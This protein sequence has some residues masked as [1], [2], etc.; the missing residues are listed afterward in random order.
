MYI[1]RVCSSKQNWN[2][3]KCC[4]K[5]KELVDWVLVKTFKRKILARVIV[6]AIGYVKLMNT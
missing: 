3:D 2:P 1:K 5:C 4:C 6:N